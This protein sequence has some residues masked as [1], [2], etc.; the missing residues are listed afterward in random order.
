MFDLPTIVEDKNDQFDEYTDAQLIQLFRRLD[1][2]TEAI[3][4]DTEVAD[5]GPVDDLT[6]DDVVDYGFVHVELTKAR[7]Y[8]IDRVAETDPTEPVSGIEVRN[9]EGDVV[10]APGEP[11]DESALNE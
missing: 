5:G 2:E 10:A 8:E 7:G 4:Q 1:V 3:A 6:A 11:V 9:A